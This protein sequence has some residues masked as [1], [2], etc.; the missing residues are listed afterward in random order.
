M[1][2]KGKDINNDNTGKDLLAIMDEIYIESKLGNDSI[3]RFDVQAIIGLWELFTEE[4]E[5]ESEVN[6]VY[7]PYN[8]SGLEDLE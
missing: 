1:L 7:K 4:R 6:K 2:F 8:I 3:T 5:E